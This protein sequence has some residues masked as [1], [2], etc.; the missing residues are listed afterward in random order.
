MQPKKLS[1]G[2]AVRLP[3][4]NVSHKNPGADHVLYPCSKASECFLD[5]IEAA[6]CLFVAVPRSMYCT[7]LSYWGGP[8]YEYLVISSE[9]SAIANLALPRSSAE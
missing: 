5:N 7:I 2:F 3:A 1:V 9:C 8:R 4:L 6:Y